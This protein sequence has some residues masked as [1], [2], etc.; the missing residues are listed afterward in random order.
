VDKDQRALADIEKLTKRK[1]AVEPLAVAVA[2]RGNDGGRDA[3]GR[4][5][6]A[7]RRDGPPRRDAGREPVREPSRETV[8]EPVRESGRDPSRD[9]VDRDRQARR[10]P[11]G[12]SRGSALK[13]DPLFSKPYEPATGSSVE[14]APALP[15]EGLHRTHLRRPARK[16]AALLGGK[17][18]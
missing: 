10:G 16:V 14:A 17:P 6:D 13:L 18:L 5:R 3:G 8:R 7:N 2:P 4:S 1:L 11:S 12:S 9:G 15:E